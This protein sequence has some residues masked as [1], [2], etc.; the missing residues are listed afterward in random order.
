MHEPHWL[1]DDAIV[2]D[3]DTLLAP[4]SVPVAERPVAP[5]TLHWLDDDGIADVWLADA[6][7][8]SAGNRPRTPER[9]R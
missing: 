6:E 4:R 7:S 9:H 3:W 2:R 1:D 5:A 8:S